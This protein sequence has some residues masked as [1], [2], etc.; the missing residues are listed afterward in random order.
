MRCFII[1]IWFHLIFRLRSCLLQPCRFHGG[2]FRSYFMLVVYLSYTA[3][4]IWQHYNKIRFCCN[5]HD[6]QRC[7]LLCFLPNF[8]FCTKMDCFLTVHTDRPKFCSSVYFTMHAKISSN[9]CSSFL[10]TSTFVMRRHGVYASR[11]TSPTRVSSLK[12]SRPRGCPLSKP[13]AELHWWEVKEGNSTFLC[14][15]RAGAPIPSA[16]DGLLP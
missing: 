15:H 10:T 2:F 7:I 12:T 8:V 14:S 1:Q 4:Q 13:L 6:I 11:L 5:Y 3:I 16:S 9:L